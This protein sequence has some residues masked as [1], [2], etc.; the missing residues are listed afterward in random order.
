[1]EPSNPLKA[2]RNPDLTTDILGLSPS[3]AFM[4]KTIIGRVNTPFDLD[5]H[6]DT[7]QVYF[8]LDRLYPHSY[9][10]DLPVFEVAHTRF[11]KH[12]DLFLK[13]NGFIKSSPIAASQRLSNGRFAPKKWVAR[14]MY[15]GEQREVITDY[16]GKGRKPREA[17]IEVGSIC[18]FDKLRNAPRQFRFDRIQGN[19]IWSREYTQGLQ[20]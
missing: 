19:V 12:L 17:R 13:A 4:L 11:Q 6:E 15:N 14:F 8:A 18:G 2:V 5:S 1:M 7:S 16:H 20:S 3:Q 10:P 9:A